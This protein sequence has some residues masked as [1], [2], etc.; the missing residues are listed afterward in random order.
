[1]LLFVTSILL[2]FKYESRGSF[3][4]K[5]ECSSNK[6]NQKFIGSIS[7]SAKILRFKYRVISLMW[8][9]GMHCRSRLKVKVWNSLKIVIRIRRFQSS[10]AFP[11]RYG[12]Q[13]FPGL[14]RAAVSSCLVGWYS[15]HTH[16]GNYA[17]FLA[18]TTDGRATA[19]GF[20]VF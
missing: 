16:A 18:P 19:M 10:W 17:Y 11:K 4:A 14:F 13:C 9:L 1:M 5:L 15:F 12:V 6:T 8:G 7:W 20:R 2:I 3:R